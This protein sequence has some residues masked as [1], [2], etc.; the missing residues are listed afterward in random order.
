MSPPKLAVTTYGLDN[1]TII[2]MKE[3]IFDVLMYLFEHYIEDDPH[4][5]PSRTDLEGHLIEAGFGD[6]EVSR[7]FDWLEGL[8]SIKSGKQAAEKSDSLRIYRDEELAQLSA[9]GI[10]FLHYLEQNSVLTPVIREQIIDRA[11]A[12]ESHPVSIDQL[13][14]VILMVLFNQPSDQPSDLSWLEDLVYDDQ[15]LT[16]H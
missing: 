3:N 6:R 13:K 14:W 2:M 9:E 11:Q 5:D 4:S 8:A 10:G 16:L 12:L 1:R 15:G 7:A